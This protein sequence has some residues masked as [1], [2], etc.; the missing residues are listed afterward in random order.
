PH[1]FA[2]QNST[3]YWNTHYKGII[4]N[5]WGVYAGF[6]LNQNSDEKK[7]DELSDHEKDRMLHGKTTVYYGASEKVAIK[8]GAETFLE[9]GSKV[10]E[11]TK[12]INDE[13][14]SIYTEADFSLGARWAFRFGARTEYSSLLEEVNLAPRSS[15][16]YK[17][18]KNSQVSLAYGYFYQKPEDDFL[19]VDRKLDF[20]R[21]THLIANYQ[22]IKEGRSFRIEAYDKQYQNLVKI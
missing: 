22:W 5:K 17:T 11:I 6:A 19:F 20:E 13:Y 10:T 2:N 8:F 3:T 14:T 16:A 4:N 12:R 1:V 18:G 7:F 15:M 9:E 21:A